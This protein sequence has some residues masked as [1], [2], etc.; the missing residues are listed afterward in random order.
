MPLPDAEPK[1]AGSNIYHQLNSTKLGDLTNAEFAIVRDPL[2]LND[3]SEDEL[4]RLA[5]IGQARQSL[6]A[7]SSGPIPDTQLMIEID[8][9]LANTYID[10]HEA[11]PGEVWQFVAG[12]ANSTT[13]IVGTVT[14]EV[15]IF[16]IANSERLLFIDAG[17][18]SSSDF[19]LSEITQSPIVYSYGQKLRIRL[20]G[21]FTSAISTFSVVRVR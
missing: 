10:I 12:C 19:P 14:R 21:T 1:P 9:T 13:G 2:F 7:S 15:D 11:G 4:R 6:S 3:R 17:S 8:T 18:S 5:L 16:G 20:E